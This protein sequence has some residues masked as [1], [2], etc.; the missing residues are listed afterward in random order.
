MKNKRD[1]VL[2]VVLGAALGMVLAPLTTALFQSM[3][4]ARQGFVTEGLLELTGAL[5]SALVIQSLLGGLFGGVV[6]AATLPFA[7]DGK[8]LVVRSLI[9]FCATAAAFALYLWGSRLITE[10][11]SILGW[12]LM[13]AVLYLLIWLGRWVGWYQEVVQLRTMLGLNP[14]P[15]PLRWRE[16]L[17]YVPFALLTCLVM[18]AVLFWVDL[19]FVQDVPVFSGLLYP[20][21]GLPVVGF[22][23]GLSLGRHKGLCLLYPAL[24]FVCY[25]PAVFLV[26]NSS[27]LF[28]CF[29]VAV[30]AL[31]GVLLGAWRRKKS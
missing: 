31:M 9:H 29:M 8:E 11:L 5:W 22:C 23:S 13:L 24:C 28:H 10:P 7:E 16:T 20:M 3:S 15:S 1:F 27:A 12:L 30:P 26:F 21:I 4:A 25:L 18:P 19:T 2:R 6:G 14:G 17:S